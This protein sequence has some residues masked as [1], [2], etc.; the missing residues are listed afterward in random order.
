MRWGQHGVELKIPQPRTAWLEQLGLSSASNSPVAEIILTFEISQAE[1]V[2]R[3][4]SRCGEWPD[5]SCPCTKRLNIA[6]MWIIS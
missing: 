2:E 5:R 1:V 6:K 3:P 4:Q